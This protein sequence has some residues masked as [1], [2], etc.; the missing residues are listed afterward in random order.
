MN[1]LCYNLVEYN[2]IKSDRGATGI[3]HG[4]SPEKE[5]L[6]SHNDTLGAPALKTCKTC[7]ESKPLTEYS[8]YRT[9]SYKTSCKAC[10]SAYAKQRRL[11]NPE[12]AKEIKRRTR[13]KNRERWN[14]EI[15]ARIA[16]DPE[17]RKK[18]VETKRRWH[19][20]NRE[21]VAKR[22]KE[23]YEGAGGD[24]AR[25]YSREIKRKEP[26]K[27]KARYLVASAVQCGRIPPA[28]AMVCDG[29]KEAQAA[30]WH[31]HKGYSEEFALDV[32]AL[33]L[34]CH[35]MEHREL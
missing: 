20:E 33:C 17:Y 15:S 35:G 25:Q 18:R 1:E 13:E 30:E 22:R 28:W 6:M 24:V 14:A 26:E 29:C 3:A 5:L 23:Y 19:S 12:R 7:G 21:Y 16:S 31:H 4:L 34:E 32:I 11:E 2:H 8:I 10:A 27:Y 9:G